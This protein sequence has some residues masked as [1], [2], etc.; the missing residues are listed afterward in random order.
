MLIEL[1]R[2]VKKK[3]IIILFLLYCVNC[4]PHKSIYKVN[5]PYNKR[6]AYQ[7]NKDRFESQS[8]RWDNADNICIED[9]PI[10]GYRRKEVKDQG[11]DYII[12]RVYNRNQT[13]YKNKKYSNFYSY[14]KDNKFK[15]TKRRKNKEILYK[16]KKGDT[17]YR[18][19]KKYH[20]PIEEICRINNINENIIKAGAFLKIPVNGS[21][22]GSNKKKYA[23]KKH[24]F[25][26]PLKN[27]FTVRR[28]G[29]DGVK[30]IGIIITG[31]PDAQVI[32][33]ASG[34]VNKIGRM[35]GFGRYVVIRHADN[36]FTIYA[37]LK[38]IVVEED[39][40]IRSGKIIGRINNNKLH[41]QIDYRGK[42]LNPL[43]Y[44]PKRG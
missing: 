8:F 32:S 7:N 3:Y 23:K 30:S 35:R 31:R 5:N 39:E 13:K 10:N 34:K 33:S 18:I 19:S 43:H 4:A 15:S 29:I 2:E 28:D 41:F 37:N 17:L 16:I 21:G 12:R 11:S 44:L 40:K 38:K 24:Q 9:V 1:H 20:I 36:Y 27:I 25:S 42:S 26:W 22:E 14:N 6:S